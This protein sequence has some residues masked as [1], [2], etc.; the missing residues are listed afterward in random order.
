MSDIPKVVFVYMGVIFATTTLCVIWLLF[1]V[2]KP[3][4]WGRIVDKESDFWVRKG[5]FSA[6]FAEKFKRLEK[7]IVM[8]LLVGCLVFIGVYGL[9]FLTVKFRH[10]RTF[11]IEQ[12]ICLIGGQLLNQPAGV[13]RTVE[14]VQRLKAIKTEFAPSE[15]KH[16]L[17]DY[18][19]AVEQVIAAYKAGH[20]ME[21]YD[22]R[23][24]AQFQKLKETLAKHK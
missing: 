23:S 16:A 4:I 20:D 19:V 2:L 1:M 21:V 13:S 14:F 11:Q 6:S 18:I 24:R 5:L 15:V 10:V 22:Q 12:E 9:A 7:G 8:K 3:D 17:Q